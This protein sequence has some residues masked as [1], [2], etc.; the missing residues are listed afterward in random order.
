MPNENMDRIKHGA[1]IEKDHPLEGGIN[2]VVAILLKAVESPELS[3][4][5]RAEIRRKLNDVIERS[6]QCETAPDFVE[7]TASP[8]VEKEYE[9]VEY[10]ELLKLMEDAQMLS[11]GMKFQGSKTP[12]KGGGY[13]WQGNGMKFKERIFGG[14]GEMLDK[15]GY[16]Q[17]QTP[18]ELPREIIDAVCE[19]VVN[20]EKGTY[21]LFVGRDG[22]L[23]NSVL[24][25]NS[26]NDAVVSYYLANRAKRG[27]KVLPFRGYS[28]HQII[29]SHR[30]N[31]NTKA[32]LNSDENYECNEANRVQE[33]AEEAEA[34]FEAIISTMQSYFKSVGISFLTVDQSNWGN[35]PVAKK[36]T[37][38][39]TYG[40]PVKGSVRLATIY[41]HDKTFS[42]L[43]ELGTRKEDGSVEFAHQV[44]YGLWEGLIVPLLDHLADKH[45]LCLPPDLTHN[46]I[47]I[48]PKNEKEETKSLEIK[49]LLD[50][51]DRVLIDTSY[52]KRYG[53]RLNKHLAAGIPL[54]VTFSEDG[55]RVVLSRRD[56]LKKHELGP[57]EFIVAVPHLLSSIK[58]NYVE[59]SRKYTE[60]H[61]A[62]AHHV[63]EIAQLVKD[64]KLVIFNHCAADECAIKM[65]RA[66]T[67]EFLGHVREF[68]AKG[69]CIGCG[70]DGKRKGLFGR[71]APTP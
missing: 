67:G 27:E 49:Q 18:R 50:N 59:R 16:E 13:V 63:D 43:F 71:R 36:V 2:E 58:E 60:A 32:L 4:I 12:W 7:D 53:R 10:E 23:R 46:Q 47:V 5:I 6:L 20:L 3:L 62:E 11:R 9:G 38:F 37:S 14:F 22:S 64:Q 35:K 68:P 41:M 39:Q 45:G 26:S 24:Y 1:H 17:F 56:T 19:G 48:I 8:M 54:R 21:W 70:Q 52:N 29:R 40:A 61:L 57:E 51:P 30:D 34:E 69:N 15:L 65:E 25:A 44:G 33:T 31:V 55:G 28:R 42:K 66:L